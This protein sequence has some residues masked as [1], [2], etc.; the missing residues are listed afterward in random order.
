M[1][2]L[3]G[4]PPEQ[5]YRIAAQSDTAHKVAGDGRHVA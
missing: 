4:L 5:W 3:L 1:L 2:T